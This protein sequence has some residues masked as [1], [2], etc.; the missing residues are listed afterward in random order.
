M[1]A[2]LARFTSDGEK[3]TNFGDQGVA[4]L[5]FGWAPA[6]DASWPTAG[7]APVDNS[8]GVELDSTGAEEKLV[9]FGH[10]A[11]LKGQ[12][13]GMPAV[14]RTDNDRYITRVL[15]LSGAIDP[16]FNGGKA[17]TYNTGGTNGDNGR[18]G[19]VLAD[20]SILAGG[21]TNF[22]GLGNHVI[23][24]RLKPDGTRDGSFGFGIPGGGVISSNPLLDDG[25][26]AECYSLTRQSSGRIVT[27]GYGSA[28]AAN[29]VSTFGYAT[30]TAP[31]LVSL[32]FTANGKALDED[33]G[34]LG[35]LV[36]QSEEAGLERQEDRG[37]DVS[38]LKDDRLVYAGNFGTDPAVFVALPTGDFDPINGVGQMF[39]YDPL[40]VTVNPNNGNVSTSHFYRVAVS[41]DGTRIAAST[42]QNVEGVLLAVLKVGE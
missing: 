14:Q 2:V 42:S 37:R 1:D 4:R 24:I 29:T 39:R 13:A 35:T 40:T 25:G 28:T 33:W 26:A 27:T 32:A 36:I 7:A 17:F 30:T 6:D 21:Y 19:I 12:T 34:N 41:A 5:V 23:A 8:W 22:A 20:G 18:R 3:V 16:A 10:G 15:A 31:D 38:A 11:P 9:V